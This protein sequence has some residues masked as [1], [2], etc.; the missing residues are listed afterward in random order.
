M[1]QARAGGWGD[2]SAVWN[3]A[4]GARPKSTSWAGNDQNDWQRKM[5]LVCFILHSLILLVTRVPVIFMLINTTS[6]STKN[7]FCVAPV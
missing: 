6:P 3:P 5:V 4:F 1:L 2:P 7:I